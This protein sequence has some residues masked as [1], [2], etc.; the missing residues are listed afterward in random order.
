MCYNVTARAKTRKPRPTDRR[1]GK[2][3]NMK[4]R[5]LVADPIN[6][7]ISQDYLD[8]NLT[9]KDVSSAEDFVLA[10]PSL[11]GNV[12]TSDTLKARTLIEKAGYGISK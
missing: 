3:K 7:I 9:E 5:F 6:G 12:A 10:L 11:K 4:K 2:E 1:A 8:E